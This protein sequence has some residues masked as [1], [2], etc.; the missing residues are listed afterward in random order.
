VARIAAAHRFFRFS[1]KQLQHDLRI[2]GIEIA[3][4]LVG[5]HQLR[6]ADQRARDR[7]TLQLARRELARQL[8]SRPASPTAAI[9]EFVFCASRNAAQQQRQPTFCST[10]RL[11]RIWNA[12]KTK[13]S[14]SRRRMV[15]ASSSIA[16]RS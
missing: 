4:R 6:L 15:R 3:G 12:W 2:L 7:D 14:F 11:G 8:A 16:I 5:Q 9:S 10:V 1:A 13:P